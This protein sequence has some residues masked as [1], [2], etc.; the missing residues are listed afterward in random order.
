MTNPETAADRI[1]AYLR[2]LPNART[3]GGEIAYSEEFRSEDWPRSCYAPTREDVEALLAAAP[4][5][6]PSPPATD[7]ATLLAELITNAEEW[8]GHITVQ[9]LRRMAAEAQQQ[10]PITADK[11]A[12]LGMTD[13][14]Y[15]A[16]SHRAAVDAIRAAIPGLY[17]TVG[18]RVEDV[19]ADAPAVGARQPD[20]E[21]QDSL[22][23]RL[24]AA[25]TER[26]T[27]QGNPFSEMRRHEQGPD[28]WPA[29]HPVGPAEVAEVLRELLDAAAGGAG[30]VADE[31][32]EASCGKTRSVS[33]DEYRPCA[34]PPGHPEAYCQSAD[35]M[36]LFLAEEPSRG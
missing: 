1:R 3:L 14:E 23:D 17:A 30:G 26:F 11:A 2:L 25:L 4:A 32:G 21:T 27:S 22:P 5:V 28:G 18:L 36:H 12:A 10:K 33:G 35:G 13:A 20:T 24:E 16:H 6:A 15:R 29:S 19:L 9:E 7:R 8:D 34:L 31:T